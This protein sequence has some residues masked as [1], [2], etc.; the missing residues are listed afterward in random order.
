MAAT[1]RVSGARPPRRAGRR[2]ATSA[3]VACLRMARVRLVW[4]SGSRPLAPDGDTGPAM[5][6]GQPGL[7]PAPDQPRPGPSGRTPVKPVRCRTPD[8]PA[9]TGRPPSAGGCQGDGTD[10]RAWMRW[11]GGSARARPGEWRG[12]PAA[13]R[14]AQG[15]GCHGTPRQQTRLWGHCDRKRSPRSPP[16]RPGA[17]RQ[18]H[19]MPGPPRPAAPSRRAARPTPSTP[20]RGP[21]SSEA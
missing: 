10:H 19:P 8:R 21:G 17:W 12:C 5:E 6:R 4:R 15:K 14:P 20:G 16:G 2:S 18:G 11:Q 9:S 13:R 3:A 1:G 7:R